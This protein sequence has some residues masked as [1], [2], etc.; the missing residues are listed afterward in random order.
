MSKGGI[1]GISNIQANNFPRGCVF[2]TTPHSAS[3]SPP[4]NFANVKRGGRMTTPTARK[5]PGGMEPTPGE[6]NGV[7]NG[8]ERVGGKR[9]SE[10]KKG[11]G[12]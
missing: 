3:Q 2:V 9:T 7:G 8:T 11:G 6:D 5:T 10:K 1:S 12:R 4:V